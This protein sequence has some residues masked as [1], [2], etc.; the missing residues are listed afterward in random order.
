MKT[1]IV[2]TLIVVSFFA[3]AETYYLSEQ[4]DGSYVAEK[5][6]A[7]VLNSVLVFCKEGHRAVSGG[8]EGTGFSKNFAITKNTPE[9]VLSGRS[10]GSAIGWNC[11]FQSHRDHGSFV[12]TLRATAICKP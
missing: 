1:S 6:Q 12:Y 2:F 7:S 5:M 10:S 11:A 9:I 8:C 4:S 3:K